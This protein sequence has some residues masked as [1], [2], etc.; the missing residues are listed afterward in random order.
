MFS[1][2]KNIVVTGT[3]RDSLVV[4]EGLLHQENRDVSTPGRTCQRF[5]HLLAP[6]Y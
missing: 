5:L 6:F 4:Q 2:F 1:G 3:L